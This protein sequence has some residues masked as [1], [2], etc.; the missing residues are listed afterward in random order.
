MGKEKQTQTNQT[1][2]QYTPSAAETQLNQDQ[3]DIFRAG[4]QGTIDIQNAGLDLGSKL[5][6]G[7]NLP[8]YLKQLPFGISE[9][10]TKS[11]VDESLRDLAPQF[12]QGGILNSGV[13]AS[14]AGRTAGD[15]R[16]N[17]A[18]FNLQNLLQLLSLGVSG[19]AQPLQ[20]GTNTAGQLGQRVAGLRQVNQTGNASSYGM[21]P[22]VKSFQS[23][24]GNFIGNPF[25]KFGG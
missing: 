8:G 18:E 10:V 9:D 14:I 4:K 1:S 11:L 5:L 16:R 2:T 17:S 13:A 7:E 3:A 12:Q 25:N 6:K 20:L 22:F 23:S 19:Q 21:N 24:A 15:I